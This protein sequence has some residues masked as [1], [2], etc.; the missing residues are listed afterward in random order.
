MTKTIRE[1]V[2]IRNDFEGIL[3]GLNESHSGDIPND[4]RI[5]SAIKNQPGL[6][7]A[8]KKLPNGYIRNQFFSD[9]SIWFTPATTE[10][11]VAHI[12]QISHLALGVSISHLLA[13]SR[14]TACRGGIT[15]GCGTDALGKLSKRRHDEIYGPVLWEAYT[16]ENV[17]A[18]YPR[19]IVS[20]K[21][22]HFVNQSIVDVSGLTKNS[23]PFWQALYTNTQAE[24]FLKHTDIDFDGAIILDYAGGQSASIIKQVLSQ[25]GMDPVKVFNDA[26]S[27][28][29]SECK[30]KTKERNFK[31]SGRYEQAVRYLEPRSRF[32]VD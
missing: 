28:V 12:S 18:I 25:H 8:I 14:G 1:V 23:E 29:K 31:L 21:L 22:I 13:L 15:I 17:H 30:K 19:V 11:G 2:L 5:K 4:H 16:L 3:R 9:T 32:W 27:F 6:V 26:F 7:D 20:D 24:V 10:N